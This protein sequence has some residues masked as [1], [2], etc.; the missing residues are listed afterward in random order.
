M[1]SY[2]S[3]GGIGEWGRLYDPALEVDGDA[4]ALAIRT[5]RADR[6]EEGDSAEAV[7]KRR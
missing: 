5:R 3:D 7:G 2:G 1:E 6:R 4:C